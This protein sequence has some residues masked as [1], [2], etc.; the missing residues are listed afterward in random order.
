MQQGMLFHSL[1]GPDTGTYTTQLVCELNG[2]LNEDAFEAA[3]QAAVDAHAVFRTGFEWEAVGEPV[4]VVRR[5][6]RVK[7]RREDWRRLGCEE[8]ERFL[9]EYLRRDREQ[10]FDLKQPPLMR[11][12]L[13]RTAD[14]ETLFLWSSHHLLMDGWSLPIILKDVLAAYERLCRKEQARIKPA[15]AYRDYIA[16]LKKQDL[17]EAEIFWRRLLEGFAS[18]TP[19]VSRRT[20]AAAKSDAADYAEQQIQL[21]ES[22]TARLQAFAHQHQLTLNTVVQG[23]WALLLSSHAGREDVVFGVVLSGRSAEITEAESIVGLLI[24]TLPFRARITAEA[25]LT[26]WLKRLQAQ[27]AEI[28]QY[29]YSPLA[30][31]QEW[32][33]V[34]RGTP[35]FE[36]IFVFE[37]YPVESAAGNWLKEPHSGLRMSRVRSIERSNYPLTVWAIP[38]RELVL[39]IGYD[40]RHFDDTS[41]GGLLGDYQ[42]L[43]KEIASNP[44]RLISELTLLVTPEKQV[45]G[46]ATTRAPGHESLSAE[47]MREP[48]ES[49]QRQGGEA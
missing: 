27:Q 14:D 2:G 32:S 31:V 4:Q 6:A 20:P 18:P 43:L 19:L 33:E 44:Q 1:Y 46:A 23:A 38:G 29:E 42:T 41:I 15:R 3:W 37:N 49:G 16:W 39:K 35:L 48:A 36:S 47:E 10:R 5:S 24:N 7:L 25:S 13:V 17:G 9:E 34:Q 45:A 30:R 21:A 40:A 26:T 28:G 22:A 11:W 12:A 8:Q